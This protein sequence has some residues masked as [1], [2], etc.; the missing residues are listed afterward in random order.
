MKNLAQKQK[1]FNQK[2]IWFV[3]KLRS[4]LDPKNKSKVEDALSFTKADYEKFLVGKKDLN[5]HQLGS[6][7]EHFNFSIKAFN[8]NRV[9]FRA[10]KEH[11]RGN[12][13]VLPHRYNIGP[14]TTSNFLVI[15]TLELIEKLYG[16]GLKQ[17]ALNYLQITNYLYDNPDG[18]V[19]ILALMDLLKYLSSYGLSN[20]EIRNLGSFIFQGLF[21]SPISAHFKNYINPKELFPYFF[22]E[23]IELHLCAHH[24]FTVEKFTSKMF[25]VNCKAMPKLGETL[26]YIKVEGPLNCYHMMGAFKVLFEY[27]NYNNVVVKHPR[28]IH[29]GDDICTFE[30]HF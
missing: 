5:I 11:H 23:F 22:E 19:S 29:Q 9:D 1:E 28:C 17:Q 13:Y 6:L 25:S 20:Q 30:F 15:K 26:N 4:S 10:I 21:Q 12:L 18:T 7:A 8:E 16:E 24:N 14:S 2:T 3:Q 27:K